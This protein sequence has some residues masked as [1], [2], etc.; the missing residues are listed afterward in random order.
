MYEPQDKMKKGMSF[1]V[2]NIPS[3]SPAMS[4]MISYKLANASERCMKLLGK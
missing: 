2:R 3:L 4:S 1:I